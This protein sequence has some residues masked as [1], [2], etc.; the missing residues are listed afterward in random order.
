M[1]ARAIL[2][3]LGRFIKKNS[4]KILAG[5]A[6]AA[7]ALG[8]YFMHRE[9]PIVR[10]RLDE[11][12]EDATWIDKVKVAGPVYLPAFGMLLL[13]TGCIAG[14]CAMGEKRAAVLSGLYSASEAALMQYEDK[15]VEKLG[16]DK[17][18]E[19]QNEIAADICAKNPPVMADIID[20]GKGDQLFCEPLTARYFRSSKVEVEAA[21]NRINKQIF[22]DVW[23]TA[24]DWFYELGLVEHA[25]LGD[26]VGWNVDNMLSISFT[27]GATMDNNQSCF[28]IGYINR[29][30]MNR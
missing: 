24:N 7:E 5:V 4:G 9:A 16:K 8:F 26:Y 23:V 11:L 27:P 12:G 6:I 28:V 1:R 10:D 22:N 17:A 3:G 14:G 19:I 15:V 2:K 21:V 30:V 25:A 29:P 18:Q 20:T 13:S